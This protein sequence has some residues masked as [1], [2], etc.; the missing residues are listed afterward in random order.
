MGGH[1]ATAGQ[2]RIGS[3]EVAIYFEGAIFGQQNMRTLAGQTTHAAGRML[4]G[5]SECGHAGRAARRPI[6]G[7]DV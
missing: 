7:R 2:P 4:E 5:V 3:D 6:G 1:E